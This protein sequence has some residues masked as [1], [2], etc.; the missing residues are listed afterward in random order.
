MELLCNDDNQEEEKAAKTN[1]P[2]SIPLD[3]L[4]FS[5]SDSESHSQSQSQPKEEDK[6]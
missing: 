2:E 1:A 4:G 5:V 3:L 6:K